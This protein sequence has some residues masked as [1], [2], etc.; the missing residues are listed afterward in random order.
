MNFVKTQLIYIKRKL[1]K[2][3]S[4]F[5]GSHLTKLLRFTEK[6]CGRHGENSDPLPNSG[7]SSGEM[8]MILQIIESSFQNNWF[9]R[10]IWS[11]NARIVQ[12]QRWGGVTLTACVDSAARRLQTR[13]WEGVRR[14]LLFTSVRLVSFSGDVAAAKTMKEERRVNGKSGRL[15]GCP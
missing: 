12:T 5:G 11:D 1:L 8:G 13:F 6:R 14:Q 4:R 2:S 3:A 15:S 9:H 7:D 10:K